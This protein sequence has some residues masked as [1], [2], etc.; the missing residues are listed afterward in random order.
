MTM[1]MMMIVVVVVM[2]VAKNITEGITPQGGI[3]QQTP[4]GGA[5]TVGKKTQVPLAALV[6]WTPSVELIG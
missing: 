5:I 4:R 1:M 3:S 6:L 2:K